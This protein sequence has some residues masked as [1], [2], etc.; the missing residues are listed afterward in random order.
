[1]N[2]AP[3]RVLETEEIMPSTFVIRLQSPDLAGARPGQFVH[4]RTTSS[5][6]PLLR[7]PMSIYLTHA[8][9]VSLLVR[10]VGRGSAQIAKSRPGETLDVLGPLGKPFELR[11][12]ERNLLMVGGGYGVAPLIGLSLDALGAE[13]N[14]TLLV[15]AATAPYV[16]PE[17]RI[18]AGV[19][20]RPA[21]VDGSVGHTGFVTE[22]IA[23]CLAATDCVYACGPTPMLQAVHAACSAR[24]EMRVEVSMEQQMGCAMGVCLGCVIP[25][26]RGYQRVCRDGPVFNS[27]TIQWGTWNDL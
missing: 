16:F 5:Y 1:M 9:G 23:D 14:V 4:I 17:S 10:D 19:R 26:T 20:Y 12:D 7:R 2:L 11:P 6:D 18:P 15:G 22:L 24:P 25:T 13:C 27:S 3:A 21:T 8:D